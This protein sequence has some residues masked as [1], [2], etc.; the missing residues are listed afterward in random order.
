[1]EIHVIKKGFKMKKVIL[2]TVTTLGI[3]LSSHGY[4]LYQVNGFSNQSYSAPE[5]NL[6]S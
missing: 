1:M 4:S 5:M 2:A 3:F 6:A